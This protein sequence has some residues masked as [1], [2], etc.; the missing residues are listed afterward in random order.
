MGS[1]KM[2]LQ[3][4]AVQGDQLVPIRTQFSVDKLTEENFPELFENEDL[5]PFWLKG[6]W[7]A[8]PLTSKD[9]STAVLMDRF[10]SVPN[11][12]LLAAIVGCL[13]EDLPQD[14]TCATREEADQYFSNVSITITYLHNYIDYEIVKDKPIDQVLKVF[15]TVN[16]DP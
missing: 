11:V 13:P 7:G 16:V 12:S 1:F 3:E 2:W 8:V 10:E 4:T 6:G 14:Q 5:I 15:E 9:L